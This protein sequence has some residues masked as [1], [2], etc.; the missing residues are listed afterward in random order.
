L[1]AVRLITAVNSHFGIE[2]PLS[3]FFTAPTVS[4]QSVLLQSGLAAACEIVVPIRAHGSAHPIFALPGAGSDVITLLPLSAA[5]DDDQPVYGI[6]NA[7][8]DSIEGYET[9]EAAALT[10]IEAIKSIQPVGPYSLI[11]HSYGGVVAYEMARVLI[12]GGEKVS[13]LILLDS[14]APAMFGVVA[15]QRNEVALLVSACEAIAAASGK[16][17]VVNTKKLTRL[18]SDKRL[19]YVADC[20]R[21][22]GIEIDNAQFASFFRGYQ[23]DVARYERYVPASMEEGVARVVLCAASATRE[24]NP[25]LPADYGWSLLLGDSL[26]VVEIAARASSR[27]SRSVSKKRAC[28]QQ[29]ESR[30]A[31]RKRR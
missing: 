31:T 4:T 20:L 28:A 26:Q 3:S 22:A 13:S 16:P 19:G 11:G 27:R 9:V 21:N 1:L 29:A 14:I 25:E 24:A 5:Y 30:D 15:T 12:A 17:L 2:L 18:R 23:A 7:N 6:R 8:P 10:N